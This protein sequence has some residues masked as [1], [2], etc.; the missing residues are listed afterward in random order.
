[1]F[2]IS[3]RRRRHRKESNLMEYHVSI[4]KGVGGSHFKKNKKGLN[5]FLSRRESLVHDYY[6]ASMFR[7]K[8][9]F[10]LN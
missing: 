8:S 7:E 3:Q 10:S 4:L 6:K 5:A 9:Q 1:M 2:Y